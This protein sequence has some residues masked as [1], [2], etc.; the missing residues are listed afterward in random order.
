LKLIDRFGLGDR[1]DS[2]FT[3]FLPKQLFLTIY[4]MSIMKRSFLS[5]MT[6]LFSW[7]K[8]ISSNITLKDKIIKLD[9][10]FKI[11]STKKE[12]LEDKFLLDRFLKEESTKD[13]R[14]EMF[15]SDLVGVMKRHGISAFV[16]VAFWDDGGLGCVNNCLSEQEIMKAICDK[17]GQKLIQF[18]RQSDA[19]TSKSN[20]IFKQTT[21]I[22]SE[23]REN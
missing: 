13:E 14:F 21:V 6:N 9:R 8:K 16:G 4:L 1:E 10:F 17:M 20:I 2:Y 23:N 3:K 11:E 5:V 15:V 22:A 18:A 19:N 12:R 7:R